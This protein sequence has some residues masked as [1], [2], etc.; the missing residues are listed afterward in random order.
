MGEK[1][2]QKLRGPRGGET[3]ILEV[4]K[5]IRRTVSVSPEV[6]RALRQIALDENRDTTEVVRDAIAAY[7][8]RRGAGKSA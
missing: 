3:T 5:L 2:R 6:W 4:G 1:P 8:E 7:L